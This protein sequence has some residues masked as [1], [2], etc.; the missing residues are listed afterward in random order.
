[1]PIHLPVLDDHSHVTTVELNSCTRRAWLE[2]PE[3]FAI[4][5]VIN[6]KSLWISALSLSKSHLLQLNLSL[7]VKKFL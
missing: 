3:K 2:Q 7:S 6:G 4:Y 1:M 5:L